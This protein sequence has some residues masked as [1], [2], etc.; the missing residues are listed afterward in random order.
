MSS[1]SP[2]IGVLLVNLGTPDSTAVADVRRYLR[3]FLGDPQVID[4]PAPMRW[5][6]LNLI[7]LPLRPK[8]SAAQYAKIWTEQG[9]PLLVHTRSLAEE[10]AKALGAGFSLEFGMRYGNP[11]LEGAL[12]RLA[13]Q[14]I[15]QLLVLPLYPQETGSSTGS[16]IE[17]V[18]ELCESLAL[19]SKLQFLPPF[20]EHPGFVSAMADIARKQL[21]DF[22]PDHVLL[23]FHG[24][25]ERHIHK[26]AA[27]GSSCLQQ[28]NCCDAIDSKNAHCYRAQCF[29]TGRALAKE[30]QLEEERYSVV[31]QSRLGMAH[32]IEP[33][34]DHK[35]AELAQGDCKRIAVLCPAFVAD[36]LETVEEIGIRG[37]EQWKSL[38]GEEL[39]Q[40]PCVNDDPAWV[41]S[42]ASM[43]QDASP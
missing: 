26:E 36:C 40:I 20:Y 3:E 19:T 2:R 6:L 42:V 7:I 23:S 24:V 33:Y 37:R 34:T 17:R 12:E 13:R 9:S 1:D 25:P 39:I 5:L 41:S 22:S 10:V 31:F 16:T 21:E 35:I 8:K 4:L 14:N 15:S 43:I 30:L 32:W 11:S 29:A 38:G 27:A 18:K 28:A